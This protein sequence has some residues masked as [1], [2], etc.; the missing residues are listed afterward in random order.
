CRQ[1][2]LFKSQHIKASK[3][4]EIK[5]TTISN[6]REVREEMAGS[7]CGCGSACKCG[8]SCRHSQITFQLRR[9]RPVRDQT[10]DDPI[11]AQLAAE[12]PPARDRPIR[13]TIGV[14]KRPIDSLSLSK[15]GPVLNPLQTKV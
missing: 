6:Q 7:N 3:E 8:D 10:R 5:I 11:S 2:P 13:D 14:H 4:E 12:T 15:G 9:I 1:F